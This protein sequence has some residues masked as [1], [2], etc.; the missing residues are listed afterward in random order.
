MMRYTALIV[1]LVLVACDNP[2]TETG[3]VE[4]SLDL[5]LR[6]QLGTWGAMPIG[7]V[8]VQS[9]AL[10]SLGQS[11]FFD[12]ILSGNRD[13]SCATCHDVTATMGDGMSLAVG[14]GFTGSGLHRA[15]GA[16]RSFVP[17]NAPTLLN[18][19]LG[20]FYSLWDGRI[21]Q[22]FGTV[23]SFH[24]PAGIVLPAGLA[25]LIAAQAMLPVLNR[26]EMRGAA[27]DVDVNGAANELAQIADTEAPAIWRGVMV[28]V[29]A[30]QEYAAKFAAA[31]PAV[32]ASSLGFQH[33]AN[34]I[35]AFQT[36]ALT[37]TNSPFDRY[38]HR[39]NDALT[40]QE[41]RGALLFFGKARCVSCH[42]GPLLGG[43]TFANV[44][45]PQIGPGMGRAAPLDVGRGEELP[46]MDFYKFA[47]R[48]PPLRNVELTAPYMHSGAYKTLEAVLLHYTNPDS[49]Q[50]HY[51]VSQLDPALRPL[52]HGDAATIDAVNNTLDFQV[53]LGI[54][55]DA[56]ER[57]QI[58]AFLKSLTDPAAKDLGAIV[59]VSVPSG[60]P[61][62]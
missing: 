13:V 16:S 19:G 54:E 62:K 37:R 32:P 49:A 15:P 52:H 7:D 46:N 27:G 45:A 33:A 35:A 31:Y 22:D 41:K 25:N 1:A 30:I 8:P 2:P 60:L 23:G 9:P 34:A 21:N 29:L 36:H 47:F 12:R 5:V 3:N 44:G 20:F 39:D 43:Q 50:R 6:Q 26:V 42:S 28:R 51:D 57:A 18:T 56:T 4:P 11:L 48:A 55:M 61:I 17:R 14:T 40:D 58:I 38:L 59:P 53:R 10:V 24:A